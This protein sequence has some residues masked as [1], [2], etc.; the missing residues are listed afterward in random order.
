M[1]HVLDVSLFLSV[2]A[3]VFGTFWL[4]GAAPIRLILPSALRP[5]WPFFAPTAGMALVIVLLAPMSLIGVPL[6]F[7]TWIVFGVAILLVALEHSL[8]RGHER[9]RE[10]NTVAGAAK[11]ICI[12]VAASSALGAWVLYTSPGMSIRAVRG[13]TDFMPYW[14]IGEFAHHYGGRLADY[15]AQQEFV[16][17]DIR[18]HITYFERWGTLSLI[19]FLASMVSAQDLYLLINP[20]LV[21]AKAAL[22]LVFAAIAVRAGLPSMGVVAI[23]CAAPITYSNLYF[24]YF[25]FAVALPIALLVALMLT[26]TARA[27]TH[28]DGWRQAG[29]GLLCGASILSHSVAFVALVFAFV[30]SIL[31]AVATSE[32]DIRSSIAQRL[33]PLGIVGLAFLPFALAYGRQVAN[34]VL[35]AAGNSKWGWLWERL[36]NVQDLLGFGNTLGLNDLGP[37]LPEVVQ[38]LL[39]LVAAAAILVALKSRGR[40]FL[41][42]VSFVVFGC[43]SAPKYFLE[44]FNEGNPLASHS[45][46]KLLFSFADVFLFLAVA[47]V[48]L[49]A[50]SRIGNRAASVL[51]IVWAVAAAG[52]HVFTTPLPIFYNSDLVQL[53]RDAPKGVLLHAPHAAYQQFT[54]KVLY[55]PIVR[56][57]SRFAEDAAQLRAR[58]SCE[59]GLQIVWDKSEAVQGRMYRTMGQYVIGLPPSRLDFT[60][61]PGAVTFM[62]G[63][64]VWEKNYRWLE[65]EASMV[66]AVPREPFG[67]SEYSLTIETTGIVSQL[68]KV[69]RLL[70]DEMKVSLNVNGV[71]MGSFSVPDGDRTA[72]LRIPNW[73]VTKCPSYVLLEF[74]APYEVSGVDFGTSDTKRISWGIRKIELNRAVTPRQPDSLQPLPFDPRDIQVGG[75]CGVDAVDDVAIHARDLVIPKSVN[76]KIDGWA[77]D[78]ALGTNPELAFLELV[79]SDRTYWLPLEL[80]LSR[81]DVALAYGRREMELSGWTV[82]ASLSTLQ[83]GQYSLRV[84][85]SAGRSTL[86]CGTTRLALVQ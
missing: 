76:V 4:L 5:Y 25:S 49:A 67:V 53:M 86:R 51:L 38:L 27:A 46:A 68:R 11:T 20:T 58:R 48:W 43:I 35:D 75:G 79:G 28:E 3:L 73:V 17:S 59:R 78:V 8:E 13:S 47:G 30:F 54:Q 82:R 31:F 41:V 10:L 19:G 7:L 60:V 57:E 83:P 29:L 44:Y 55:T 22:V 9:G 56:D 15:L 80:G 37:V 69:H 40:V 74:S 64:N 62:R 81:P 6:K 2:A 36:P 50:S 24:T 84:I 34:V 66:L 72:V 14:V 32:F 71:K 18:A 63:V 45:I 33:K 26:E 61:A 23:L 65:K 39:A 1:Q 12:V 52:F 16:A 42:P 85:Q 70:G 21:A 77:A